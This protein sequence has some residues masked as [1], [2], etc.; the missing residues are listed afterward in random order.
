MPIATVRAGMECK[1]CGDDR[2]P[3]TTCS[4]CG[5]YG[6]V[7][8]YSGDPAGCSHCGES[9]MQWPPTCKT[10]GKFRKWAELQA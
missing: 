2:E 5:G 1:S 9:G 8:S 4:W 10:C 6:M 7:T 3:H